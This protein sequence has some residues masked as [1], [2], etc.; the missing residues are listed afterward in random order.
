MFLKLVYTK[1]TS[2][3]IYHWKPQT[4]MYANDQVQTLSVI[5]NVFIRCLKMAESKKVSVQKRVSLQTSQ[6]VVV[7][8]Q[9]K[10]EDVDLT[11]MCFKR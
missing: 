5:A 7:F 9:L 8:R 10:P 4:R 6:Y 1:Q 2:Q 11:W 3:Y